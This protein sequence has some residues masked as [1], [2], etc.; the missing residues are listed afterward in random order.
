S[1]ISLHRTS[2]LS[3]QKFYHSS[4][5]QIRPFPLGDVPGV[6]NAYEGGAFDR[7][8]KLFAGRKGKD[9]ILFAPQDERRMAD[10]PDPFCKAAL[11]QGQRAADGHERRN[12]AGPLPVTVG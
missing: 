8:V 1:S 6:G 5:R 4:V 11:P 10:V 12:H 3:P 9:L 7:S 2:S